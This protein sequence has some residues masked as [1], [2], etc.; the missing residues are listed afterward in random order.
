MEL[1]HFPDIVLFTEKKSLFPVHPSGQHFIK[2]MSPLLLLFKHLVLCRFLQVAVNKQYFPVL[3]SQGQRNISRHRGLSFIFRNACDQQHFLMMP[4]HMMFHLR[5]RASHGF[6]KVHT[7]K[8]GIQQQS[9]LGILPFSSFSGLFLERNHPTDPAVQ[10]PARGSLIF[11]RKPQNIHQADQRRHPQS[12]QSC[13]EHAVGQKPGCVGRLRRHLRLLDN[14][15]A[16]IGKHISRHFLI[17]FQ[18]RIDKKERLPGIRTCGAQD[19]QV[20]LCNRHAADCPFDI[21]SY[22][23]DNLFP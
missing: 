16:G 10:L 7:D 18:G 11:Y 23:F 14:K 19:K 15:K 13:Q 8:R 17:M 9:L 3:L 6:G 12:A 21:F 4:A 22:I 1:K 2:R 20:R 5:L